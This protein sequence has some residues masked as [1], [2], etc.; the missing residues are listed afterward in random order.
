MTNV[1]DFAFYHAFLIF[2][3]DNVIIDPFNEVHLAALQFIFIPLF[4]PHGGMLG[5]I[6]VCAQVKLQVIYTVQ[7]IT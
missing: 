1:I 2:K 5:Q 7:S 4:I 6:I 3:E